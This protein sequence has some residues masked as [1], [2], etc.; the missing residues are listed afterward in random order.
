QA[1]EMVDDVSLQHQVAQIWVREMHPAKHDLPA[2]VM[3]AAPEKLRIGYFS[4]DFCLHAVAVL[5]AEVFE[6]HDRNR[7][8][9][10]A[11]S[12]QRH[13]PDPMRSRLEKAF[14]RF[15]DVHDESDLDVTQL[16]R[17]HQIDIAVD[18]TGHTKGGRTGIFAR[19][20]APIQVAYVGYAA[21]M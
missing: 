18:L 9:I 2:L 5:T 20:A 19:R 10:T 13:L 3:G 12:L 15:V 1:L 14:D 6:S 8:E 16:A 21:T 17:S 4:A 11:F 7:Y